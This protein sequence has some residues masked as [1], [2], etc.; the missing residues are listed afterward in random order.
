[1]EKKFYA[2]PFMAFERFVPNHY[3]EYCF[4]FTIVMHCTIGNPS[5]PNT[6]Y[7]E[8]GHSAPE[9]GH[10][11]RYHYCGNNWIQVTITDGVPQYTGREDAA[12]EDEGAPQDVRSVANITPNIL[13]LNEGDDITYGEWQSFYSGYEYNHHGN[14]KVLTKDMTWEGHPNH[15]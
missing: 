6:A 2:R 12:H 1:M 3:C 9:A 15:S 10:A 14:G 7:Y 8:P 5:D 4:Q 13:N 11:H